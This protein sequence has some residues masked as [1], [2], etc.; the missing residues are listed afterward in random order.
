TLLL[1][2]T[3]EAGTAVTV[4]DGGT[5]LGTVTANG[6]GA[7]SFG[8]SVSLADGTHSFT[9]VSTDGA[10]VLTSSAFS[11]TVDTVAPTAGTPDLITASDSGTS[12]TDNLTNVTTSTFT[13]TAEAG[14]TVTIFDGAT[15]VGS[16]TA[17]GGSYSITTSALSDGVHSITAKATDA[18]GNTGAASGSLSVTIDTAGP[19]GT[20]TITSVSDNVSPLTGTLTSGASSNDST[21]TLAGA[22]SIGNNELI[23]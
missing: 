20:T 16:G 13:G 2:G 15:A 7:W 12:S 4:K 23:G 1:T 3:A 18:A 5:T 17:T 22:S 8:P 6:S 14:S 10:H 9:A 21:L 19:A 11:E